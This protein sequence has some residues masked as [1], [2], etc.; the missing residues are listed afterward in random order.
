MECVSAPSGDSLL[1]MNGKVLHIKVHSKREIRRICN[2]CI[3]IKKQ[4]DE[5]TSHLYTTSCS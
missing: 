5:E 3:K 1:R 2:V 4:A